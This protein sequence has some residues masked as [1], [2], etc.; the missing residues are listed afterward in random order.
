MHSDERRKAIASILRAADG[1]ISAS[2]LAEK[3]S[4][5]RQ[6]VVG[7]I[8]L[9]RSSGEEILATPRGYVTPKEA[10][11]I[12]R[13]IA[14]KHPPQE[15]EAELNTIVD[16]GCTVIDVTVEHP[17]CGQLTG[18]LQITSRYEVG[19]FI[20][21]C[22][23]AEPC[24]FQERCSCSSFSAK[25]ASM[26]T[27]PRREWAFPARSDPAAHRAGRSYKQHRQP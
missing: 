11:G 6:I 20:E 10:R 2:A 24:L 27:N 22:R 12:I 4:V 1:P 5:S 7:D 18:P 16:N 19:Q 25:T 9:L 14:V 23:S 13:R 15:M 3:F 8:A 26:P 17:V 21:R